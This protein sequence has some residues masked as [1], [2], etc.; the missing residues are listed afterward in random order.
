MGKLVTVVFSDLEGSKTSATRSTRRSCES[1]SARYFEKMRTVLEAHGGKV[2]KYIGDAIMAVFGL[3]AVHEGDAAEMQTV[4]E[5]LNEPP[6]PTRSP[7]TPGRPHP[8][9]RS[10]RPSRR[11]TGEP[12]RG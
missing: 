12:G 1:S 6:K 2:E 8:T 9:S 10:S 3:P 4:L 5:A 7:K 11:P